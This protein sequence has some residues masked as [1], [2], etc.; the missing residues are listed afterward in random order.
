MKLARGHFE[1]IE[2]IPTNDEI[3]ELSTSFLTMSDSIKAKTEEI[4]S[5]KQEVDRLATAADAHL[6][7]RL[8]AEEPNRLAA[9]RIESDL[10]EN[11]R[12]IHY[13]AK[14]IAKLVPA[15]TNTGAGSR[16]GVA[17]TSL[18]VEPGPGGNHGQGEEDQGR[19]GQEEA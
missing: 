9:F 7:R 13:F 11:L 10:I 16:P 2:V 15:A 6:A 17:T 3:G 5:A 1:D 14:R 12:R 19:Q 8:T 4:L 18:H